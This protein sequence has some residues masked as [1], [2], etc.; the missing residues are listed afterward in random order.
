M[1]DK[2]GRKQ[3]SLVYSVSSCSLLNPI[4]L[5]SYN[6][7]RLEDTGIQK[8]IELQSSSLSIH[9]SVTCL[10]RF[11]I[12]KAE[13]T[14]VGLRSTS[15]SLRLHF[16][17]LLAPPPSSILTAFHSAVGDHHRK[18]L[19]KFQL[20]S[21]LYQYQDIPSDNVSALPVAIKD[22]AF[23][24]LSMSS[25]FIF[26]QFLNS[27]SSPLSKLLFTHVILPTYRLTY[28]SHM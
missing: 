13:I 5:R 15:K 3:E 26:T 11:N 23:L 2:H 12:A 21:E 8:M 7:I 4:L 20:K 6:A 19:E 9:G 24:L 1:V 10:L 14:H 27:H 25:S 18:V 17:P 28:D 22:A 16:V